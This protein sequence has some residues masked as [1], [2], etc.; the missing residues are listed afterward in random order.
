MVQQE[1][2]IRVLPL[3]LSIAVLHR[4][5]Q[6]TLKMKYTTSAADCQFTFVCLIFAVRDGL[7]FFTRGPPAAG[8]EEEGERVGGHPR[9]LQV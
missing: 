6:T 7:F 9:T 2:S 8:R 5:E 3:F 4:K 1:G